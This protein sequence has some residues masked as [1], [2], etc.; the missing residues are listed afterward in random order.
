MLFRHECLGGLC[1]VVVMV[2]PQLL[3]AY[4]DNKFLKHYTLLNGNLNKNQTKNG[5]NIDK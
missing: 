4:K 2:K 5:E 3:I 1:R